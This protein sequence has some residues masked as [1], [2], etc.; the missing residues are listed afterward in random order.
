MTKPDTFNTAAYG[1]EKWSPRLKNHRDEIGS[2]WGHC[3]IDCEWAPLKAVLLHTPGQEWDHIPDPDAAQMLAAP[4]LD[5]ARQQHELIAR[6]YRNKHIRVD[7]VTPNETPPPNLIFCADLFFMTPEGAILARPASTMRAGEER[8]IARRLTDLGIPIT[9]TLRGAATFEG[10]DAQ[11]LDPGTVLLG[12]GLRTNAEGANQVTDALHAMGVN[13]I[14]VDLPIGSMH[15]M[16]MLRFLD[17]DLAVGWPGRL[18]F[19]AVE[20]LRAHG[21]GVIFIPDQS[22]AKD[23]ALNFVTLGPREILMPSGKPITQNFYQSNGVTCH[24]VETNELNKAA[25]G[26]GCLTGVLER[27]NG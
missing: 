6:T 15:L 3:G 14:Q 19:V 13:V 1:G 26:I 12:R 16:G 7:Y 17:R 11:W 27:S 9:R 21:Y 10:A 2:L 8:W 18:S 23:H 24:T 4:N 5:L 25:G 22:E 20:A